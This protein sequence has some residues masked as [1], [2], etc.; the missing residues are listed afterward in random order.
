M[1]PPVK[2][3]PYTVLPKHKTVT[4]DAPAALKTP[5]Q[6][7]AVAPVVDDRE[8]GVAR[9]VLHVDA[10]CPLLEV[11]DLLAQLHVADQVAGVIV[12]R[13]DH[14][15][16]EGRLTEL[17]AHADVFGDHGFLVRETLHEIAALRVQVSRIADAA[18]LRNKRNDHRGA[19]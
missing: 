7:A 19:V 15:K 6:P 16:R 10:D 11:V 1:K 13:H 2:T 5:A 14:T 12:I 18:V 4:R 17:L 8:V 9:R 3:E